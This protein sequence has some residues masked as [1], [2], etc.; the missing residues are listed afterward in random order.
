MIK[1]W[2]PEKHEA[3]WCGLISNMQAVGESGGRLKPS[4]YASSEGE[5]VVIRD[6]VLTAAIN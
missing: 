5:V 2:T 3:T 1:E 4:E 6:N